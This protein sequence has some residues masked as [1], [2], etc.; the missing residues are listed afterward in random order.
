MHSGAE[1]CYCYREMEPQ[2]AKDDCGK[3]GKSQGTSPRRLEQ[4]R[5]AKRVWRAQLSE[6]QKGNIRARE[7][8]YKRLRRSMETREDIM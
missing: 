1:L 5:Q 4:W 2:A 7:R 6:S 3:G 8:Y